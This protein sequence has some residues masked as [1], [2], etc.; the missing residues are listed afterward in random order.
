MITEVSRM[1]LE[2]E[3]IGQC[4]R[5]NQQWW[6]DH[7]RSE[8]CCLCLVTCSKNY[9]LIRINILWL[10]RMLYILLFLFKYL[11][12]ARHAS[13]LSSSQGKSKKIEH[14]IIILIFF[15]L[16]LVCQLRL[17]RIRRGVLFTKKV[18]PAIIRF[19]SR[20]GSISSQSVWWFRRKNSLFSLSLYLSE[21]LHTVLYLQIYKQ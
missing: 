2:C 21:I 18:V 7:D 6:E 5:G 19:N 13:H 4:H 11:T 1:L 9:Y 12:A 3:R 10:G 14:I 16:S 20:P 8:L 15:F 17:A